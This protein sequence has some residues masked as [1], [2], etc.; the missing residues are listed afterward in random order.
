MKCEYK[1][2]VPLQKLMKYLSFIISL[3]IFLAFTKVDNFFNKENC[4]FSCVS[5]FDSEEDASE[6]SKC[7]EEENTSDNEI[8]MFLSNALFHNLFISENKLY[9]IFTNLYS[10][11]IIV[12]IHKPPVFIN[13]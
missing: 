3:L 1:Y 7:N 6:E 8:K 11:E 12:N 4:F 9:A 13:A 10:F 2:L 5:D